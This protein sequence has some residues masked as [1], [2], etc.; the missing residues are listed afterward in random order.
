MS[1][2]ER[3]LTFYTIGKGLEPKCLEPKWLESKATDSR[4]YFKDFIS[5]LAR[6]GHCSNCSNS[7]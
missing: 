6:D 4:S 1:I 2:S 5:E 3:D 7:S